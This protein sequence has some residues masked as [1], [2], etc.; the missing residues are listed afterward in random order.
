MV[1][2]PSLRELLEAGVHFGHKTSRWHPLME[3]YIFIKK[4]GVHIINLEKVAEELE[5]ASEFIK[6]VASN[7]GTVIFVGTKKQAQDI[8]K[9]AA[10]DCGMPYI[11]NRWIGGTLTNF[12]N[13]QV[14]IKK[15]QQQIEQLEDKNS[16]SLSKKEK[17][18]LSKE[19]EK[20]EKIF[21]GLVG[22]NKR[23]DAF[24]LF[25][26]HDEKNALAEANHDNIPCVAMCDT[27]AN[28][29]NI[30][31]PIPS[32]DDATKSLQLFATLFSKIIKENKKVNKQ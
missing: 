29:S 12:D 3:K 13:I 4:S 7:G 30:T 19:I 16:V 2:Q 15:Y 22:L 27:N 25:G 8:V 23:P 31:Y 14:A 10:M 20:K 1:K 11:N 32:N 5:K 6:K 26:A 24:I 9:K 17:A 18:K 28:P 21:G